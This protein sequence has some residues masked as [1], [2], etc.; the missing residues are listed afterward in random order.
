MPENNSETST[1]DRRIVRRRQL[2]KGVALTVRKGTM[3]LGPNLAG[4]G[5]EL[6]ND[7][8]QVRVKTELKPGEEIEVGMTGI[9]RGKP[10]NMVAEVCWCS[11][12]EEDGEGFVI[13]A[14]FRKRLTHADMGLFV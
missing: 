1:A 14:R 13:G 12:A 6:S 2:K 9:G 7:G 11:P 4:G 8:I 3:G 5:V 10:I